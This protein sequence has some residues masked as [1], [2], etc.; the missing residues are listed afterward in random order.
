MT[1]IQEMKEVMNYVVCFITGKNIHIYRAT[2][3]S[4][5]AMK[6]HRIAQVA[7]KM[8]HKYADEMDKTIGGVDKV[9]EFIAT[10]DAKI[11]KRITKVASLA[12]AY[13]D[14]GNRYEVYAN[15]LITKAEESIKRVE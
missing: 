14:I 6:A 15:E 4:K 1:I 9:D 7:Y 11:V 13:N 5:K 3:L 10:S 2:K 12:K 8:A